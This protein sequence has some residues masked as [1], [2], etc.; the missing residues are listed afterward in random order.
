MDAR[1]RPPQ[2]A[3]RERS[4]TRSINILYRPQGDVTPD[5]QAKD[6]R[7]TQLK[8]ARRVVTRMVTMNLHAAPKM[9]I[10]DEEVFNGAELN[11]DR[12]VSEIRYGEVLMVL[13]GK[14]A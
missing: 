11:T 9:A 14:R 13:R 5:S 6:G 7:R 4:G 10:E 2:V 8:A 1:R 12:T 3:R